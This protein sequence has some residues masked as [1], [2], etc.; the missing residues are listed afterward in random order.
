MNYYSRKEQKIS[1]TTR[2]WI[3]TLQFG[4]DAWV[5]LLSTVYQNHYK[6]SKNGCKLGC[7]FRYFHFYV[8]PYLMS[9]RSNHWFKKNTWRGKT[10]L[11]FIFFQVNFWNARTNYLMWRKPKQEIMVMF[12]RVALVDKPVIHLTFSKLL[13]TSWAYD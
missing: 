8:P 9:N 11:T 3:I 6:R 7:L 2:L 5:Q 4:S 13:W 1:I 12:E 10:F